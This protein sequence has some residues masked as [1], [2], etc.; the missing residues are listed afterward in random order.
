[1]TLEGIAGAS[2]GQDT[3][4]VRLRTGRG[5]CGDLIIGEFHVDVTG[6]KRSQGKRNQK[7]RVV[8]GHLHEREIASVDGRGEAGSVF[9]LQQDVRERKEKYRG[10]AWRFSDRHGSVLPPQKSRDQ[11]D[12]EQRGQADSQTQH[13]QQA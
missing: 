5:P 7:H 4:L 3:V 1:M 11:R 8:N 13:R 9:L 12:E 10:L 2:Q 6:V